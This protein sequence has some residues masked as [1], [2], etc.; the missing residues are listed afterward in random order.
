MEIEFRFAA[1]TPATI[2]SMSADTN[3][4]DAVVGFLCECLSKW[5]VVDEDGEVLPIEPDVLFALPVDF[6]TTIAEAVTGGVQVPKAT[7]TGSF[8]S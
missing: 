3:K 5:E 6:L 1:V 2:N 7:T 8:T 4:M